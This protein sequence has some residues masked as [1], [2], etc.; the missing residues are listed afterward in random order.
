M[1][2]G[3]IRRHPRVAR[4]TVRRL[5]PAAF[6]HERRRPPPE[7]MI[8]PH[9]VVV[10]ANAV[11][12]RRWRINIVNIDGRR[13]RRSVVQLIRH[14]VRRVSVRRP[15]VGWGEGAKR[16]A[17]T[18]IMPFAAAAHNA[19]LHSLLVHWVSTTKSTGGEF[20][21]CIQMLVFSGLGVGIIFTLL[22][23]RSNGLD[24]LH[25]GRICLW[26]GSIGHVIAAISD[27]HSCTR[28]IR[29]KRKCANKFYNT[30]LK[31]FLLYTFDV[32]FNDFNFIF[33]KVH[34]S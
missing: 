27:A 18:T 9:F 28:S 31:M 2:A 16:C 8:M 20:A 17:C 26:V 1:D 30:W 4:L 33:R 23:Q 32:I 12:R 10:T 5:A 6:H 11:R 15:T 22:Q 24:N 3:R 7:I 13:R 29:R 25:V 14:A 34:L 19:R 21:G